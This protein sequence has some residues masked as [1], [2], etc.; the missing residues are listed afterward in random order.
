MGIE[1]TLKTFKGCLFQSVSLLSLSLSGDLLLVKIN[2]KQQLYLGIIG[3]AIYGYFGSSNVCAIYRC[4]GI[5]M[6]FSDLQV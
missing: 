3:K 4:K 5:K 1:D 2:T 6:T